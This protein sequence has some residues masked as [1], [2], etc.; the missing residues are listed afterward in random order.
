MR[1]PAPGDQKKHGLEMSPKYCLNFLPWRGIVKWHI[2]FH[3][4]KQS[5]HSHQ[6]FWPS[7]CEFL[8]PG[9]IMPPI[10]Q[11]L[12]CCPSL[13]PAATLYGG[14]G[15]KYM[16]NQIAGCWP[17]IAEMHIKKKKKCFPKPR[18]LHLPVHRKNTKFLNLSYLIFLNSS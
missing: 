13:L 9:R 7:K 15:T 6:G 11:P 10:F 5:C 12:S 3:D 17:Q 18:L 8:S 16:N 14:Q 2:Y 4:N 1:L